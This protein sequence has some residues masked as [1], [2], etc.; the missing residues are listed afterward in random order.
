MEFILCKKHVSVQYNPSPCAP[1]PDSHTYIFCRRQSLKRVIS[2]KKLLVVLD[3]D[4]TLLNSTRF[5]E[6]RA[7][8]MSQRV[9][10]A[11]FLL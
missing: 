1:K 5:D 11:H 7:L 10:M 2:N 9:M 4:H 3:L 6:V 8:Y